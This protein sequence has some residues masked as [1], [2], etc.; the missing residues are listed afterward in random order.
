M[1]MPKSNI[2]PVNTA[3]FLEMTAGQV[4]M[5]EQQFC[6]HCIKFE[7]KCT[8]LTKYKWSYLPGLFR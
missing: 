6:F 3:Y 1:N 2:C 8:T 4:S 7:A 5:E